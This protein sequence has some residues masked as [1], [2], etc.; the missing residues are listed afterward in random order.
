MMEPSNLAGVAAGAPSKLYTPQSPCTAVVH[1]SIGPCL[2]LTP[3]LL[4]CSRAEAEPVC[5]LNKRE[6]LP[7][8]A[9]D[10]TS[11]VVVESREGE[12]VGVGTEQ[13]WAWMAQKYNRVGLVLALVR[14]GV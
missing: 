3:S 12:N 8:Q 14:G 1:R 7:A 13:G 4:G 9:L 5:A 10:S 6:G 11:T 2:D